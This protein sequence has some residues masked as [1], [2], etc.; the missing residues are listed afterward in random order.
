MM[1]IDRNTIALNSVGGTVDPAD[2]I[3]AATYQADPLSVQAAPTI[4]EKP[5]P[6]TAAE[7]PLV[8]EKR[9]VS[10]S[11]PLAGE[12]VSVRRAAAQLGATDAAASLANGPSEVTCDSLVGTRILAMRNLLGD[13]AKHIDDEN[14][15]L[16]GNQIHN[17]ANAL[18]NADG[19][20]KRIEDVLKDAG[21]DDA[22]AIELSEQL[23]LEET[24]I[25][26]D[27]NGGESSDEALAKSVDAYRETWAFVLDPPS[28]PV[29][30]TR[31]EL[32]PQYIIDHDVKPQK[33]YPAVATTETAIPG[34]VT[35]YDESY[36]DMV[37]RVTGCEDV[38]KLYFK[39][40]EDFIQTKLERLCDFKAIT[41]AH[42][43]G[44]GPKELD[45][46]PEK[47][48]IIAEAERFAKG[49]SIAFLERNQSISMLTHEDNRPAIVQMPGNKFA[50]LN[51][52]G[53]VK[54]LD[55]QMLKADG[56]LSKAKIISALLGSTNLTED[57]RKM[58]TDAI[59]N[60]M[61]DV[62]TE[63]DQHTNPIS[64][65][66]LIKIK[67]E[68]YLTA[69]LK[70]WKESNYNATGLDGLARSV[71]PFF[72]VIEDAKNDAGF[73]LEFSDIAW[74]VIDLGITLGTIALSAGA[75]AAVTAGAKTVWA[76]AGS[77]L[78]NAFKLGG[79]DALRLPG[80]WT[81]TR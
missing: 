72:K 66:Q 80:V 77:G 64:L 51:S 15:L 38:K 28:L 27:W 61:Y 54:R 22:A 6:D 46:V 41:G 14:L 17:K 63:L 65:K 21:S 10:G 23:I 32:A 44:F 62:K 5:S 43:A 7:P 29:F 9:G 30:K 11:A 34:A 35:T 16:L 67:N 76:R 12:A 55:G 75:G 71:V 59:G 2:S 4:S 48:W 50:L 8:R 20:R 3:S 36:D 52:D 49:V 47:T 33:V 25:W 74:D 42:S 37:E 69:A 78:L 13:D 45:Q 53:S 57:E 73:Q 26:L 56:N 60:G 81:S 58:W 24:R 79:G 18:L 31:K 40:F 1:K 68:K 19:V 39:Q 70:S